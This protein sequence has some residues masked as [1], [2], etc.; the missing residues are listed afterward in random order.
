MCYE[1]GGFAALAPLLGARTA[2]DLQ[3]LRGVED[4]PGP[5]RFRDID[6][7]LELDQVALD[8]DWDSSESE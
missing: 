1:G 3:A 6:W 2:R 8:S 7:D 5:V 4:L